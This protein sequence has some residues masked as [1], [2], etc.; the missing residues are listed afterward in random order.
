MSSD[1]NVENVDV[2]EFMHAC[3]G[4]MVNLHESR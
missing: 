4:R 2:T 3:R 1:N